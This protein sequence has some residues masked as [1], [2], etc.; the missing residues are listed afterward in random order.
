MIKRFLDLIIVC[1]LACSLNGGRAQ[2]GDGPLTAE[3]LLQAGQD[4]YVRRDFEVARGHFETFVGD[5]GDSEEAALAVAAVRPLLAIC[6]IRTRDFGAAEE[7]IDEVLGHEGVEPGLRLELTFWKGVCQL[8]S[9]DFGDAQIAFGTYYKEAPREDPRRF[10][11]AILFGT[12]YLLQE[13]YAEA[14]SFFQARV[15][16]VETSAPEAAARMMTLQL[17]ALL[18]TDQLDDAVSLTL[19]AAE[20]FDQFVQIVGLQSLILQLGSRLLESERYYEA[21]RCFHY[22]WPHEQLIAL[23]SSRQERLE[24]RIRTLKARGDADALVFQL[25]G[26]LTRVQRELEHF[27][28]VAHYNEALRMRLASAYLGLQR[29]REGAL[30]M[31]A[32]LEHM[33]TNE[34]VEGA[35]V[36]LVQ[37]WM[38]EE[39]WDRAAASADLYLQ[40]FGNEAPNAAQVLYMKGQA[41][42]SAHSYEGALEVFEDCLARYPKAATTPN[43]SFM[44]GICLLQL[45]RY[46][47]AIQIFREVPVAYPDK[48][49]LMESAAYWEGMAYSFSGEHE[50]CLEQMQKVIQKHPQGYYRVDA[51]F[52]SAFSEH[53]LA[54]YDEAIASFKT[55]VQSHADSAYVDEARLLMGDAYMAQGE[56]EDGMASYA[57]ISPEATRFFEEGYFKTGKA[58]KLSDRFTEMEAHFRAF[59]T[60]HPKSARLPEAL[61]QLA[62]LKQ[63]EGDLE[64]ARMAYWKAL[65]EHGDDAE[66]PTVLDLI[67]GLEKLYGAEEIDALLTLWQGKR[68]G[69]RQQK[70]ATYAVRA[71]WA[72]A[73]ARRRRTPMQATALLVE[74][75]PELKPEIHSARLLVDV[76]DA[77]QVAGFRPEAAEYYG[78]I[79][80]WHPNALERD[81]AELGLG[82][83]AMRLKNYEKALSHFS[84][85]E[86]RQ[87]GVVSVGD[88]LLEKA[89][90][91]DLMGRRPDAL[92]TLEKLLADKSV[93]S[94]LKAEALMKGGQWLGESEETSKALAYYERVYLVY[95]RYASLVAAA[96]WS[97]GQLLEK[98][99]QKA[100]AEEVYREFVSRE[101]LKEFPEYAKAEA[102]LNG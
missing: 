10:E 98:L 30:I 71:L 8:Q 99:G 38:Q 49:E 79:A 92:D 77:L 4:A 6:L 27:S 24:K 78:E 41:W 85:I 96:Y 67:L 15:P 94:G 90:C 16:E 28:K 18:Q 91:L 82:R 26:I 62:W 93:S 60:D 87:T 73:M 43:A 86:R 66:K 50:R 52:R 39:R 74:M 19:R 5:Y 37:C 53:A 45:D 101:E 95:G 75:V 34:I 97:R 47:E 31:E 33:E 64:G 1:F 80:R 40:R 20:R 32:M 56:L 76:A 84:R 48:S 17:H 2:E 72:Q 100:K 23:Q 65:D 70:R 9:A 11:A 81:R 55:F 7:A 89:T 42:Q 13:Q 46:P 54:L 102:S 3:E 83:E 63:R 21:I 58:L 57:A 29:Y 25:D 12:G 68:E 51:I 61:H 88:V 44:R 36:N 14:I 59:E 69:A 22:V 35:S